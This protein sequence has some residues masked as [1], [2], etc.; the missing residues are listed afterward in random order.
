MGENFYEENNKFWDFK[1]TLGR[2]GYILNYCIMQVITSLLFATPFLY[3]FMFHPEISDLHS[4]GGTMAKSL[5]I[6]LFILTAALVE[7]ILI[8]PSVVRR[9]RDITAEDD[10]S[11][12][13][14]ISG[15]LI[16]LNFVVTV[17]ISAL[18]P[19]LK[20]ISIFVL[21]IL[22]FK[23]GKITSAK[24][25][26]EV[27]KFNWGAFIGTWIWGIINKVP[28]TFLMLPLIFTP[29]GVPFMI[30]CG[31][32]G[33][34]WAYKNNKKA[35]EEFHTAQAKQTGL[36]CILVPVI[37][38]IFAAAAVMILNSVNPDKLYAGIQS[39]SNRQT[40]AA[41][42]SYYT[43]YKLSDNENV[44]YMQPQIWNNLPQYNRELVFLTTLEFV[45]A[46]NKQ[47]AVKPTDSKEVQK[48]KFEQTIK[49]AQTIKILSTFNNEILAQYEYNTTIDETEINSAVMLPKSGYKFNN[50]PSLP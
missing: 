32:K 18:L 26:S 11:K 19:V 49:T 1:G 40:Q 6:T 8:F 24:P 10:E 44:F 43:Q 29:A 48:E 28:Q 16:L 5:F 7:N 31:I 9:V 12:T 33:N 35:I 15:V 13:I 41:I 50:R 22:M 47:E 4:N 14:F 25:E 45:T 27:I 42:N 17:P 38:S 20:W 2:R 39:W 30:I 37:F 23:K 46:Q 3:I 34:E 21:F 36:M